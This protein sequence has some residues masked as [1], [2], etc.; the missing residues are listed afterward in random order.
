MD[1]V[2][3][4]HKQIDNSFL[5][6]MRIIRVEKDKNYPEGVKYSLVAIDRKTGKRILGFNNHERKGHHI[7]RLKRELKYNFIDEWK[8]IKDFNEEYERMKRRFL[9]WK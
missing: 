7:H 2:I 1:E 9:K 6:D 3:F 4:E 8:L 5:I